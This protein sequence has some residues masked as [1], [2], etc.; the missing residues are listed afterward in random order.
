VKPAPFEYRRAGSVEEALA[1]LGEHGDE[2][3][4]LAG[5]QS[6]VPMMNLRLAR[7]AVI[8]DIGRLEL[9]GVELMEG[10]I[11]IGALT[12][13]RRLVDD[14]KL[15]AAAPVIREAAHCIAHPT[16]RNH[17]TCGGSIAN[18]DPT[19]EL[20]ALAL[21]LDGEVEVRSAQ[22]ARTISATELFVSAF[23]TAL[24]PVE[25]IT[26][27][28]LRP[29]RDPWGGCFIELAE[30]SGDYA[31]AAVGATVV[32]EGD[33][34]AD[35]RL[36]LSGAEAIPVR[37]ADAEALLR[38]ERLTPELVRAAARAAPADHSSYGDVRASAEYRRYL[39]E[40]LAGEAL[41]KAYG[42]AREA[43]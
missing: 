21:L 4:L 32:L 28:V 11:R 26:A 27:T 30:R 29:P 20:T 7:P 39:L 3:R 5:G 24:E 19:A 35:A 1:L 43:A 13:H 34:I 12:R 40:V 22:G 42:R 8:V 14:R 38:G 31:I 16:I 23:V 17:G 41:T 33:T 36:V 10:R 18:A 6:L 25:M 37:A 2:A 9:E 15:A